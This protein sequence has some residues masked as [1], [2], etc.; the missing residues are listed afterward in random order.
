LQASPAGIK[1]DVVV[2]NKDRSGSFTAIAA[3]STNSKR[4]YVINAKAEACMENV[5]VGEAREA[6]FWR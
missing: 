3:T 4:R 1:T 6:D 2:V 5:E